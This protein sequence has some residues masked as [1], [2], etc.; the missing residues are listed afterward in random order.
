VLPLSILERRFRNHTK[1][2]T[3]WGTAPAK[4][5]GGIHHTP[6]KGQ[7]C[8]RYQVH[9]ELE[10]FHK[11]DIVQVKGRRVKQINALYSDGRLAFE[12][13]KGEPSTARPKDCQLL[14]R[15]RTVVWQQVG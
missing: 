14:E 3:R 5:G 1:T 11:G 15:N 6:S 13:V 10:G 9:E 8:V 12:R 7:G 4:Y 2:S